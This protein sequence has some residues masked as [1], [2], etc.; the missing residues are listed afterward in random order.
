MMAKE[1]LVLS[2]E[3]ITNVEFRRCKVCREEKPRLKNGTKPNGDA[4]Y[5]DTNNR[6][7]MGK[8]CAQC[9]SDQVNRRRLTKRHR[10]KDFRLRDNSKR[11]SYYARTGK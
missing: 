2:N 10:N 8:R 4:R 7:W 11:R 9:H 1:P 6:A 5:V 3:I